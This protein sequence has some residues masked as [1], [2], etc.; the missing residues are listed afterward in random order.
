M[1]RPRAKPRIEEVR[2]AAVVLWRGPH[3]LLRQRPHGERW[4]GL[5]DFL[6]FPLA[7]S[8]QPAIE[9]E[10]TAGIREQSGLRSRS[11]E[12]IA[13][14]KHGVTRFRIELPV[15]PATP[16]QQAPYKREGSQERSLP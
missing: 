6:R 7:S 2:E 10:L 16:S 3:V 4:A 11:H 8:K 1:P 9:R 13:T 5:W 12:H 15:A 14:L